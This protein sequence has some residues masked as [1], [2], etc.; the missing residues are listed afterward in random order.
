MS[1]VCRPRTA[2]A[3]GAGRTLAGRRSAGPRVARRH[4]AAGRTSESTRVT[5]WPQTPSL[6]SPPTERRRRAGGPASGASRGVTVLKQQG[7]GNHSRNRRSRVCRKQPLRQR[8]GSPGRCS[9]QGPRRADGTERA[10]GERTG[11]GTKR[12]SWTQALVTAVLISLSEKAARDKPQPT[13]G[14]QRKRDQNGH[15]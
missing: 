1:T 13:E 10:Q 4:G 2:R 15:R 14:R 11:Q 9:P 7:S 3:G 5:G 12:E 8:L 6:P